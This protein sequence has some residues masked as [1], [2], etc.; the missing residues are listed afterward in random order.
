MAALLVDNPQFFT[1]GMQIFLTDYGSGTH[2]EVA[3]TVA[4]I[5]GNTIRLTQTFSALQVHQF[6]IAGVTTAPATWMASTPYTAG[7]TV[8]PPTG[9]GYNYVCI[10]GGTS[11]A[12]PP[13]WPTTFGA[14]VKDGSVT[15]QTV[16]AGYT[17]VNSQAAQQGHIYAVD[18][19]GA[20]QWVYPQAGD[21]PIDLIYASPA[22]TSHQIKPGDMAD[23][24]IYCVSR[25]GMVY[26][27]DLSGNLLWSYD[28]ALPPTD[29]MG[30]RSMRR[31]KWISPR[32]RCCRAMARTSTSG[33]RIS[34]IQPIT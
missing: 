28:I 16:Y 20:L 7:T 15:W 26:A 14:T 19:S 9:T 34:I 29:A 24:A 23:S 5:T 6:Y 32:R 2:L 27:L 13:A 8:Q 4:S 22:V 3:G 25:S 18:S 11:G 30:S 21:D 33:S 1:V 31:G 10:A 17:V 12:T